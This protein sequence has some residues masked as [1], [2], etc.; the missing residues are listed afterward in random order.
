MSFGLQDIVCSSFMSPGVDSS[1]R[2]EIWV[3]FLLLYLAVGNPFRGRGKRCLM[4]WG[5]G[6]SQPISHLST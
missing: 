2:F 3:E 6:F 5:G 4:S 1:P